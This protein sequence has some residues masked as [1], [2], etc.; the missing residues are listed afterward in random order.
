METT[1][2]KR[3]T[4]VASLALTAALFAVSAGAAV[5]D[6]AEDDGNFER[7]HRMHRG[8]HQG[9]DPDRMVQHLT[10]ELE[11]DETQQQEIENIVTAAKPGMDALHDRVEANMK[12][13][14]ELEVSDSNYDARL[15]ELAAEKGAIASEQAL[16][17][18]RLKAEVNAVL[19]PEQRQEL[20][21]KRDRIRERFKQREQER[22]DGEGA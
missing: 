5:A 2:M 21:D 4:R 9:G 15:N 1:N 7:K 19:T 17:H 10:R 14:R 20:A 13:M 3:Q 8:M 11:L 16:L 22:P 18:G 12:A 6:Q